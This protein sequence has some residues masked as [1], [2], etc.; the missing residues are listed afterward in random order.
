MLRILLSFFAAVIGTIGPALAEDWRSGSFVFSDWSGPPIT[1]Y[2]VE[3][4]PD[5][6]PG[7]PVVI[8]LHGA[9][10][11]ADD[12]ARNWLQLAREYGLRVYAPE[13]SV[14]SFPGSALYNLGGIGSDGQ[15]AFGAIEPLFT[16][17]SQRGG[18]ADGFFLFGHSAG[19]Q[20]VHRA[21]L[22]ED[23]PHLI[24]AYAAN[25][26]WYTMPDP[27]IPW[28]YGLQDVPAGGDR[29]SLWAGRPL[30]LLLGDQDTDLEDPNLRR[31]PQ[32]NAQGEHR[33]ARGWS[34][35]ASARA[36]AEALGASFSWRVVSVPGVAHDNVGMAAAAAAL[37]AAEAHQRTG[38][39]P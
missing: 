29:L 12:Y 13:F 16:A 17:V 26:G 28:P 33:Y 37:I 8:V 23:L 25:A 10:R 34:F 21:L 3:P 7:A 38:A 35:A 24:T 39:S 19:A 6:M 2:F 9:T 32:A 22:F 31:T 20:F 27:G 11:N 15:G 36:R 30:V 5:A 1:V 14:E 4:V 18:Q